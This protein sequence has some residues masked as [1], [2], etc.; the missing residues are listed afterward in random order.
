[1]NEETL[2]EDTRLGYTLEMRSLY[3]KAIAKKI[4]AVK[5]PIGQFLSLLVSLRQPKRILE[6]GTGSGYSTL[7]LLR[8]LGEGGRIVTLERDEA[9]YRESLALFYQKPIDVFHVDAMDFLRAQHDMYDMVFLDCEKR[10]YPELWPL[11]R[12]RLREGGIVV[13]DNLFG[14]SLLQTREA[15][16]PARDALE[17][18]YHM[19][20]S[21][22]LYRVFALPWEDGI[23]VAQR[24]S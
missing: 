16:L 18:F 11:I 4:P 23:L 22:T 10:L 20:M 12:T 3:E 21:D 19:V 6:I 2:A 7:W 5:P 1:M 24:V 14:S 8:W 13:V 17:C 9:R 15:P